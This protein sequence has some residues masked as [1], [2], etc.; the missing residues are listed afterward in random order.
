MCI[1]NSARLR[2]PN[3]PLCAGDRAKISERVAR[4][5]I[6]RG[7]SWSSVENDNERLACRDNRR[8]AA[9]L[10][11]CRRGC[12]CAPWLFNASHRRAAG[13]PGALT[14]PDCASV[15][16]RRA[17][18]ESRARKY[19]LGIV[20]LPFSRVQYARRS[21]IPLRRSLI[22]ARSCEQ[23]FFFPWRLAFV[24]PTGCRLNSLG[25]ETFRWKRTFRLMHSM[26]FYD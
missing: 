10:F 20:V 4:K 22:C 17:A 8:G 6:P 1:F 2:R 9:R 7:A 15:R 13:P 11:L 21:I 24:I 16:R 12:G 25:A 14:E 3:W 18:E 26:E 23:S 5:G 19:I